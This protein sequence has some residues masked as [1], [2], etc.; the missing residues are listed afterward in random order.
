MKDLTKPEK[1]T[2]TRTVVE[3]KKK[4]VKTFSFMVVKLTPWPKS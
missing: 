4:V 1:V 3:G 2:Y